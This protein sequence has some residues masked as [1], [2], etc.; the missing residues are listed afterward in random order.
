MDV[1]EE[2]PVDKIEMDLEVSGKWEDINWGL[3][4][5]GCHQMIH[6]Q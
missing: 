2:L 4:E 5:D 1:N 6:S 3:G